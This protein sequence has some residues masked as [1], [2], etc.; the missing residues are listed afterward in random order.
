MSNCGRPAGRGGEPEPERRLQ[1]SRTRKDG[2]TGEFPASLQIYLDV[3]L[4]SLGAPDCVD[5]L[6]SFIFFKECLN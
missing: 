5:V 1:S 4:F 6:F 2:I 3:V